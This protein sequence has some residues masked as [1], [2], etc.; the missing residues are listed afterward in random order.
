[1]KSVEN[2]RTSTGVVQKALPASFVPPFVSCKR[3]S[4]RPVDPL[5]C[6]QP[7]LLNPMPKLIDVVPLELIV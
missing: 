2:P 4:S 6:I 3:L 5:N 7:G 1:M